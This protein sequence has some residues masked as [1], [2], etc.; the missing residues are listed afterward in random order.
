MGRSS[1]IDGASMRGRHVLCVIS[2]CLSACTHSPPPSPGPSALDIQVAKPWSRDDGANV[3]E[4][5]FERD[6]AKCVLTA[7]AGS[8]NEMPGLVQTT[9]FYLFS[10]C[11]R[12]EGYVQKERP[13]APISASSAPTEPVSTPHSDE[14]LHKPG[15]K[16]EHLAHDYAKCVMSPEAPP[17]IDARTYEVTKDPKLLEADQKFMLSCMQQKGY[18]LVPRTVK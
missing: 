18:V 7:E 6:K 8:A 16:D 2:V 1:K 17:T 15:T 5:Q 3:T 4:N 11:M 14:K 10:T 12:A 13:P 9:W